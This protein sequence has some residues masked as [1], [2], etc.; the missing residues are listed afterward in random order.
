MKHEQKHE[1]LCDFFMFFR[2]N[3]EKNIGMSIEQFV[4]AFL[5]QK[6]IYIA[7]KI[8]GMEE[9]AF[10]LFEVAE[11]HLISL[12]YKVVNPMKLPHNHDKKWQSYMDEC[13]VELRKCDEIYMLSNWMHSDGAT[14]EYVEAVTLEMNV[15][16]EK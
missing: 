4:D 15:I 10:E 3:G 2:D 1:L 14:D 16:F 6:K 8:T 5:Q 9:E 13:L 11:K 12:G 7:G